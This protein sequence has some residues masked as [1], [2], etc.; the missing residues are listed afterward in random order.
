V[1]AGLDRFEYNEIITV[2]SRLEASVPARDV[3]YNVAYHRERSFDARIPPAAPT[4]VP[5]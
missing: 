4:P 3:E 1:L 5:K 2:L